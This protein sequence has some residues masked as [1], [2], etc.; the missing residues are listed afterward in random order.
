MQSLQLSW[1]ILVLGGF[2]ISFNLVFD[3]ADIA[4]MLIRWLIVSL[5]ISTVFSAPIEITS[6]DPFILDG[7]KPFAAASS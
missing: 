5:F 4:N 6:G 7:G 1:Y 2:L 3:L